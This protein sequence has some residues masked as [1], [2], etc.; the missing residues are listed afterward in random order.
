MKD[1]LDRAI[2][3]LVELTNENSTLKEVNSNLLQFNLSLSEELH[4]YRSREASNEPSISRLNALLDSPLPATI[5]STIDTGT[6]KV[7]VESEPISV[8]TLQAA[9]PI[10]ES[11]IAE[12]GSPPPDPALVLTQIDVPINL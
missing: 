6:S 2:D 3:R 12:L 11:E 7:T 9:E 10:I 5:E 4:D 8:E 1:L